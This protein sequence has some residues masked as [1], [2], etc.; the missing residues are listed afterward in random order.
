LAF[1][2]YKAM[3]NNHLHFPM[4]NFLFV[5]SQ[6]RRPLMRLTLLA[7]LWLGAVGLVQAQG[8]GDEGGPEPAATAVPLDGGVSL[9]LAAGTAYG[10]RRLRRR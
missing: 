6:L 5:L 7:G 3:K 2:S 10:L 1:N 4:K 8:P 9:L